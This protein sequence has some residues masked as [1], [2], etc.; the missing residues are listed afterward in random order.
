MTTVHVN[1][2]TSYDVHIG[3]GILQ[4][5]G[6][7]ILPLIKGKKLALITDSNV[8]PLYGETVR[9]SLES[10]GF[11]V[12]VFTFPAGERSKS[13]KTYAALLEFLAE[14]RLSRKDAIVALGGGVTGDLAGFAAATYLRGIDFVQIPTTL[15]AAVD[16]SV[17][18]KTGIDLDAGKN[19]CGAFHQPKAVICDT[20]TLT[21]LPYSDFVSGMAEVIKCGVI[22]DSELFSLLDAHSDDLFAAQTGESEKTELLAQVIA[23]CVGIKRDVVE[24]DEFEGGLRAILNF[25]HTAA[26]AIE[27]LSG[28]VIPHGIAVGAGMA[29]AAEYAVKLGMLDPDELYRLKKL[30]LAF[31][32]PENTAGAALSY[33]ISP[34]VFAPEKMAEVALY[35]KKAGSGEISLVLPIAI[36]DCE[37]VNTPTDKLTEFMGDDSASITLTPSP[38]SGSITA[39]VSKSSVHRLMICAAIADSP[40]VIRYSGA[41]SEDIIATRRCLTGLGAT[42][43]DVAGGVLVTP[44]DRSRPASDVILDCGE[45]GSTLRFLIPVATALGGTYRFRL[46]GRLPERPL[47]PLWEELERHG[48]MISL[49]GDILTVCGDS[50]TTPDFVI[51]GGVSSQFVSGLL[52][53]V[54]LLRR[55]SVRI[56]GKTESRPYIDMTVQTLYNYGIKVTEDNGVFTVTEISAS[57]DEVS[58]EGDWSGAAFFICAGALS[59]EGITVRGLRTDSLQGDRRCVDI[60]R[61][62]G[63]IAEELPD[64][65]SIRKGTLRGITVDATDIPDLVPVIAAL[66][67]TAEG[68]TVITG[69]AR[70]RLKESDRIETTCNM[71]RA[72]GGTAT[73]CDDCIRISGGLAS[74]SAE[75]NSAGDHRI[76]MAA[77]ILASVA[78]GTV[79][80]TDSDCVKKSYPSFWVDYF[81]L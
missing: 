19:L 15:L 42:L 1:T 34:E 8:A 6:R 24:A 47:S 11:E 29:V 25:G 35:D 57:P 43:S 71:I 27:N 44:I 16:S 45:S 41:V 80:I 74:P 65:V 59:D 50:M 2:S 62:M 69:V 31:D 79:T 67:A 70:L 61:N 72:I 22:R 36:G 39:P 28:Y 52:F 20:D 9:V 77:A 66:A 58:A 55:G 75:V 38:L 76:A 56:T 63:A 51:D 5:A 12:F 21:T 73:G 10:A 17:G 81:G 40:T 49:N 54:A 46:R 32:L 18:G 4:S 37:I 30:L 13:M 48:A 7:M 3:R 14:N 23:T 68:E 53:A 60:V 26:H 33:G 64:G 78:K